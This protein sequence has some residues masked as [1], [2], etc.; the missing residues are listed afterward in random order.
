MILSL[1]MRFVRN[2]GKLEMKLPLYLFFLL[3]ILLIFTF[4]EK[5]AGQ[6]KE[7]QNYLMDMS[8]PF[9]MF[10]KTIPFGCVNISQSKYQELWTM[11]CVNNPDFNG[12]FIKIYAQ[13]PRLRFC[14]ISSCSKLFLLTHTL[15]LINSTFRC[16]LTFEEVDVSPGSLDLY[17]ESDKL[18][19]R[20]RAYV[21]RIASQALQVQSS[22]DWI[23]KMVLIRVCFR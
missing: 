11:I 4:L 16:V 15:N 19:S 1:Q 7:T 22:Q 2:I 5:K 14:L 23:G 9:K 3:S 21:S 8:H 12:E 6:I 20:V 17:L 10:P 13:L 18:G